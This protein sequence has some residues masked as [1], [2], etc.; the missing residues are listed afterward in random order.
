MKYQFEFVNERVEIDV[1]EAWVNILLD[2]DREERNNNHTETRR[3]YHLEACAYEGEDF[4]VEDEN[5]MALMKDVSLAEQLPE[6]IKKLQPQQQELVKRIFYKN[7][8]PGDIAREEGVS[9]A[10]ISRRLNKI[11]ASLRKN[12][13]VEG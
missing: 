11:Y 3:H 9:N 2:M 13:K 6:A 4:A 7:E 8:R 5:L 10:A 1:D 12:L